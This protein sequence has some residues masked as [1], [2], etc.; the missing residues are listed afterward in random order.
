ML[1][2]LSMKR[3]VAVLGGLAVAAGGGLAVAAAIGNSAPADKAAALARHV[4]VATTDSNTEQ[5]A[6]PE[7]T[8]QPIPGRMLSPGVPVPIAPSVLQMRN[9]W[10]VSDGR[11]L[12]AVYAG[13]AGDDPSAGRLVV[14]RQDL[15]AGQQ[16]VRTI[17]A[18]PTGALAIAAAPLGSSVETSAQTRVIRIRTS[19]GRLLS[20]DLATGTL[21]SG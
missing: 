12:V 1:R 17:D 8:P 2:V 21:G 19:A 4:S 18:G 3:A 9:G 20:L 6:P 14:V 5:V 11:T 16:T 7:W 15:V 10:L 13:A